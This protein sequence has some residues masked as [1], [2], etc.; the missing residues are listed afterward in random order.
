MKVKTNQKIEKRSEGINSKMMWTYGFL[1]GTLLL[2]GIS[3]WTNNP[4]YEQMTGAMAL[5]YTV[6][7]LKSMN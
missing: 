2:L 3:V 1:S 6:L 7:T 5:I 4:I